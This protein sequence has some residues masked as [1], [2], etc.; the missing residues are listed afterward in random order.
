MPNGNVTINMQEGPLS[1]GGILTTTTIST[2]TDNTNGYVLADMSSAIPG[3]IFIPFSQMQHLRQRPPAVTLPENATGMLRP[4]AQKPGRTAREWYRIENAADDAADVYI[5][6]EI[7]DPFLHD[8]FGIGI[9]ASS[10]VK[11]LQALKGKALSVHIN[12]P[13]GS[14]F[15][16]LAIYNAL[17]AHDAPVNVIVDGIAASIA[18]VIMMA[19]DTVTMAPHSMVMIHEPWGVTVGNAADHEQQV[20]VLNKIG[21][22]IAAVYAE[23]A[24]KRVNWRAKMREETWLTDED[25]LNL[26]LADRIDSAAT[27]TQNSFDLSRFRNVPSDLAAG[28]ASPEIAADPTPTKRAAEQALRDAGFSCR[29]AKVIVATGWVTLEARDESEQDAA[30]EPAAASDVTT[31]EPTDATGTV[32]ADGEQARIRRATRARELAL[33]GAQLE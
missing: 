23:R 20:R 13:G 32:A 11:E 3:P 1:G 14:V 5:Y 24:D 27:P 16:G 21:D 30:G 10:F 17:R 31:D 33:L 15:E 26:G 18:S 12:S 25:A 8:F 29:E 4:K 7:T 19:G 22:D 2:A 6:D 9:S 28:T